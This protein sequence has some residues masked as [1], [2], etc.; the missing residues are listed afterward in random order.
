MV[1][2]LQVEACFSR[3]YRTLVRGTATA[4]IGISTA[5]RPP[6]AAALRASYRTRFASDQSLVLV[7]ATGFRS[8][9]AIWIRAVGVG[10]VSVAVLGV[11]IDF[12]SG[13]RS[14]VFQILRIGTEVLSTLPELAKMS[15]RIPLLGFNVISERRAGN[16]QN[17]T[18]EKC[19]CKKAER[20]HLLPKE[21]PYPA[22]KRPNIPL[23]Q[24][25]LD[26]L[27]GRSKPL[28]SPLL[29]FLAPSKAVVLIL[30]G[31]DAVLLQRKRNPSRVLLQPV[32]KRQHKP[33]RLPKL[34]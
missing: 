10:V 12:V 34:P 7:F 18:A 8:V 1:L 3:H 2:L 28:L 11:N 13:I 21:T 23:G 19:S 31:Q 15:P 6:A 17:M 14:C 27:C 32:Y 5:E 29:Q 20:T 22:P 4:A 9:G 30:L 24:I 26:P 33:I 25:Q 16:H